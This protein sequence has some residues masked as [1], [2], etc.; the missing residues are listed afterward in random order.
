MGNRKCWG[1]RVEGQLMPRVGRVVDP[2][3]CL[4]KTWTRSNIQKGPGRHLNEGQL[5]LLSDESLD[6]R[7]S[8]PGGR[9]H[10]CARPSRPPHFPQH[11]Q[12]SILLCPPAPGHSPLVKEERDSHLRGRRLGESN[13]NA[14]Q[15][16]IAGFS[17]NSSPVVPWRLSQ[18]LRIQSTFVLFQFMS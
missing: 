10:S 18:C 6:Q 8:L 13:S 2:P 1:S 7:L 11:A 3:P 5:L 12:I 4:S 9:R 16:L 17:M 15:M 14:R